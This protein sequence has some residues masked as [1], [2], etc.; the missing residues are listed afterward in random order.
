MGFKI[1]GTGSQLPKKAVSNAQLATFLDTSDDW[2]TSKTGIKSRTICS[3]ETITDLAAQAA[4][5]ALNNANLSIADIDLLV[6]ATMSAD[7][8]MPS[9]A[10]CVLEQLGG[11]CPAF[12]VNAACSGFVYALDVADS[13]ISTR[14]AQN[15]LVVAAEMMSR[16][17]DWTDRTSSILFG[18][19]AAACVLTA[20][21]SLKYLN[22]TA[23]P[24]I[25]PLFAKASNGNNPFVQNV[26]NYPNYPQDSVNNFL[27]MKGQ[28]VYKFAVTTI[29]QEI[30][31]ALNAL[32]LQADEITYFILHQANTRI[33]ESAR[34]RLKLPL[35][36]FPMN[37]EKYG[38]M[39]AASIPV[40][41]DEM[42]QQNAIKSGDLLMLIGFGGGLTSG[43]AV[44]QW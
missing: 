33:I 3:D 26:Q 44:L 5:T 9:M 12:D 43:T 31:L 24:Q 21:D 40:L 22:V 1:I 35:E 42:L 20:G 39:S 10:C 27:Q 23:T 36:K 15:V 19:G 29:Q 34:T 18:D 30:N 14:K 11:A 37:I 7:Y 41:L 8:A 4:L 32:H 13:F 28:H 25:A 6:C 17:L 38:N 16:M 2:I